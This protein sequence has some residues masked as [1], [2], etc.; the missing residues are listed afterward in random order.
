MMPITYTIFNSK[1]I[2]NIDEKAKAS[3]TSPPSFIDGSGDVEE[4]IFYI[5]YGSNLFLGCSF[6]LNVSNS[7]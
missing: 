6:C 5:Q 2:S 1:I 4:I 7:Q 3:M